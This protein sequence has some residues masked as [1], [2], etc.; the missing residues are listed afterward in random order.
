M[1]PMR[2]GASN[3]LPLILETSPPTARGYFSAFIDLI[4]GFSVEELFSSKA[5]LVS[6]SVVVAAD[7][8]RS[9]SISS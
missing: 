6:F 3:D 2:F 1:T 9:F 4:L 8:R 7:S 5:G